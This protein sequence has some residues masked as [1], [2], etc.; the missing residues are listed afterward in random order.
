MASPTSEPETHPI[1]SITRYDALLTQPG[2]MP[3]ILAVKEDPMLSYF[4]NDTFEVRVSPLG[5]L[6]VFAAKALK[7]LDIVL[8]EEP[9]VRL[10]FDF[11][12]LVQKYTAMDEG[13]R[14]I[15]NKLHV[16]TNE[17]IPTRLEGVASANS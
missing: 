4:A 17:S 11:S 7:Y 8:V 16:H 12:D 9:L 6:G 5:G 14:A 2:G 1:P 3:D 13:H 10:S 15:F